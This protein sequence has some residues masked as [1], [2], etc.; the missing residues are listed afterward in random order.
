MN[1]ELSRELGS[2]IDWSRPDLAGGPEHK[3]W[4]AG[5]APAAAGVFLRHLRQRR[6]VDFGISPQ[7][8]DQAQACATDA[9]RTAARG[10][11]H[12]AIN[13]P[14]PAPRSAI[15]IFC[16]SR[17]ALCLGADAAAYAAMAERFT[18]QRDHW[19]KGGFGSASHVGKWLRTAVVHGACP[20][21]ALVAPLLW[22]EK[23][24]EAEWAWWRNADEAVLGCEGH[25]LWVTAYGGFFVAG[26]LFPEIGALA[27]F[28]DL[29]PH[30]L[31]RETLLI[32][33]PDGFS[34]ERAGY[35]WGTVG[36]LKE[37][38]H[39]AEANGILMSEAVHDRLRTADE[40]HWKLILADGDIPMVGDTKPRRTPT[41]QPLS[42]LLTPAG[43]PPLPELDTCLPDSG[44]YV[45]RS[46]WTRGGD[47]VCIDAG[48]RGTHVTSHDHAAIFHLIL[49][50][51]G[52]AILID[53]S[54]GHYGQN[55]ARQW[56]KSSLAHNVVTCDGESQVPALS[57]WRWGATVT[58]TI[59]AWLSRPAWAYFSGVHEGYARL[60]KPVAAARR[61][62]L[63]VRGR[64]WVLIDRLTHAAHEDEHTHELRFHLGEPAILA[65]DGRLTTHGDGGNL[66]IVPVPGT[67]TVGGGNAGGGTTDAGTLG[68]CPFPLDGYDNPEQLVYLQTTKRRGL[69]VTLMVPFT[70][71]A[72]PDV[73]ARLLDVEMDRRHVE[74][75]EA[76]AL[77]IEIDGRRDVY[78]DLHMQWN[79]AWKV[80]EFTGT[81]RRFHS[82]L[83]ELT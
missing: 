79:L 62:L 54:S 5:N 70:G 65:P 59:D 9:S 58:T 48:T 18:Q 27:R 41:D 16:L 37:L 44:Y 75:W 53:N 49:H 19:G 63:Y 46:D 73:K 66:M 80:A 11:V 74:R 23:E 69:F 32:L 28:R 78:V 12:A 71:T 43:T 10:T 60:P 30:W 55:P 56:R 57:E 42:A 3:A 76:T 64:Y 4:M 81:A 15:A 68:P 40:A 52:R 21:A 33:Q 47:S 22:L 45:M 67:V 7:A 36:E 14:L 29:A 34:R 2:L 72:V 77:E 25:N 13:S 51:R 61:K 26:L 8:L 35:H 39:L 17:E 1:P 82:R 6:G 83:G 50:S 20:D 38:V 31:E 24:V